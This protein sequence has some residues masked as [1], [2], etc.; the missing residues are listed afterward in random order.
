M[1]IFSHTT[2][3][4]ISRIYGAVLS[5]EDEEKRIQNRLEEWWLKLQHGRN[6]ALSASAAL[7]ASAAQITTSGFDRLFGSR[8][9]SLRSVGISIYLSLSSALLFPYIFLFLIPPNQ[10]PHL[11]YSDAAL[12]TGFLMTGLMPAF[13]K[14]K[15]ELCIWGIAVALSVPVPVAYVLLIG[16]RSV[17]RLVEILAMLFVLSLVCDLVFIWI[18]RWMLKEISV[19]NGPLKMIGFIA[20]NCVLAVGFVTLP[21]F[22]ILESLKFSPDSTI[23]STASLFL[24]AVNTI[25]LLFCSAVLVVLVFLLVHR[26]VWPF[27]ERSLY[28]VARYELIQRKVALWTIGT[29]LLI[30]PEKM[31]RFLCG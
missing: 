1:S 10:R 18:S 16:G 25:D 9:F 2:L 19:M 8:T 17:F 28:A 11:V 24:L 30:G 6:R 26:L 14:R 21:I 15:V 13:L 7:L 5:Y 12:I 29:A 27:L 23:L 20:L 3:T 31:F 22:L 4:V